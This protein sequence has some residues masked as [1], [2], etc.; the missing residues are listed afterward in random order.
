[1]S[2][3]LNTFLYSTP[4]DFF[5]KNRL[6][7]C[8]VVSG[9]KSGS[10]GLT[11]VYTTNSPTVTWSGTGTQ[12]DP[13]IATSA[14]VSQNLQSVL[15][16]GN[17]ANKGFTLNVGTAPSDGI[18]LMG[19]ASY[20]FAQTDTNG[21]SAFVS[22]GGTAGARLTFGG[23]TNNN[24][25]RT[26]AT[27]IN[28]YDNSNNIV[29]SLKV[30]GRVSG[31]AAVNTNEFVTLSQLNAK[32]LQAITTTGNTSSNELLITGNTLA[33]TA[34]GLHIAFDPVANKSTF[35]NIDVAANTNTTII[36]MDLHNIEFFTQTG[37]RMLGLNDQ[38]SGGLAAANFN[39]RVKAEGAFNGNELTTKDQVMANGA[40]GSR[41]GGAS[42][43]QFYLDTTLNKPIWYN[44]TSWIDA[45]G[46]TV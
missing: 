18:S 45:T 43:G 27:D 1:M 38:Q 8:R 11:Q 39:G 26:S 9:C 22:I 24:I 13:L 17:N 41:P 28:I 35:T 32:N 44:G 4:E 2:K 21:T 31:T 23:T 33:G 5:K 40:T 14:S 19:S 46:A 36:S 20:V 30:S 15:D 10:S 7:L 42:I 12:G 37:F 6:E 34:K 29:N 3:T 16:T 25:T